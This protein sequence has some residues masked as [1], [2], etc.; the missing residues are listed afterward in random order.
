MQRPILIIGSSY[1]AINDYHSVTRGLY[2]K[3]PKFLT[4]RELSTSSITRGMRG[5]VVFLL[6]S[7]NEGLTKEED[8]YLKIL[9]MD[10][11]I[12]QVIDWR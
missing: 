6:L 4:Y 5:W 8:A 12:I 2:E 7:R 10:N 9:H 1:N 11:T 3:I